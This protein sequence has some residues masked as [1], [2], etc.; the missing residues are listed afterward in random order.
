[1]NTQTQTLTRK[2]HFF[3]FCL[4]D[5][6]MQYPMEVFYDFC[7]RTDLRRETH[8]LDR[9]LEAISKSGSENN[10]NCYDLVDTEYRRLIEAAFLL[11]ENVTREDVSIE[12]FL[13]LFAHEIKTQLSAASLAVESLVDKTDSFFANRPDVAFY[14]TTLQS[15]LFN[16]MHVLKNMINTVHF[17]E[18]CFFLRAEETSFKVADFIDECTIPQHI[19]N[20]SFNK[21]LIIELNE[22]QDKTI[23]TD[24]MKLGQI[25]QNFLI[26]AYKHS[27]G[28]EI[29]LIGTGSNDHVSFSVVSYGQTI[30]AEEI[31]RIVKIYYQAE[32]GNAGNGLGLYLCE[33]YA[34]ILHGNIKITSNKG[35]TSFTI[36]I[37][38]EVK[39]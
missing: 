18:E 26:N 27:K 13:G 15:I 6:E 36:I 3:P 28:K 33:L 9:L 11:T 16:S 5:E 31:K 23:V 39:D 34:E 17:R 22:L 4:S 2:K 19:L 30:S 24:K 7:A 37:P 12:R 25:I 8:R 20:E 21:K 10:R 14:L 38:C 35:I 1:M 29:Q 32:P